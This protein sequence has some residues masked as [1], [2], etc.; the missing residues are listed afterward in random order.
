MT[1]TISHDRPTPEA[2]TFDA[3]DFRNALGAFVTGVTV[4]TTTVDGKPLGFTANSFSSISLDPPLISVCIGKTSS[5]FEAFSRATTFNVTILSEQQRHVSKAFSARGVDR[6]A[7]VEWKAGDLGAPLIEGGA[8][9]FE[10]TLQQRVDAGDHH[11]LIGHVRSFG[12][13]TNSPLGYCRGN[14]VLFHLE[15]EIAN[16]A[17]KRTRVGALIETPQGVLMIPDENNVLVLPH[18]HKIG[19]RKSQDGLYQKLGSLIE[20]F[21]VDFLFSVWQ[22]KDDGIFNIY[23]RG[24]AEGD[25]R[26]AKVQV[27]PLHAL[28]TVPTTPDLSILLNRYM[29]EREDARYSVYPGFVFES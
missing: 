7:L 26:D 2:G 8:A 14:Y 5:N 4:V 25:L 9:W 23:Y 21:E 28:K 27:V 29:R 22:D 10:C 3:R 20:D 13:N 16:L 18:A 19:S 6:F 15:Q 11:I 24:T 12:H 1:T 17:M